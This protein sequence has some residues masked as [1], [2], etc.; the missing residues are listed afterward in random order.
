MTPAGQLHKKRGENVT[1]NWVFHQTQRTFVAQ[2]LTWCLCVLMWWWMELLC[3]YLWYS[4]CQKWEVLLVSHPPWLGGA[5]WGCRFLVRLPLGEWGAVSVWTGPPVYS[6]E[7]TKAVTQSQTLGSLITAVDILASLLCAVWYLRSRG[8]LLLQPP[9]SVLFV[10]VKDHVSSVDLPDCQLVVYRRE[11]RKER[12]AGLSSCQLNGIV[13]ICTAGFN[14]SFFWFFMSENKVNKEAIHQSD[15]IW[16][17]QK[18]FISALAPQKNRPLLRLYSA[19]TS[20]PEWMMGVRHAWY[21]YNFKK[22]T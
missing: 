19:F 15:Q 17:P 22:T 14:S 2:L 21:L 16:S 3:W 1:H 6:E 13:F 18:N 5:V 12:D 20:G 10:V 7:H 11:E 4:G 9:G 8:V